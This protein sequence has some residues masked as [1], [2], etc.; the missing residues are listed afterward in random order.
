MR[1]SIHID[2]VDDDD[3]AQVTK[4]QLAGNGT[5]RF[6]I[7]LK[8]RIAKV[9]L[10][11]ITARIDVDRRH[12]FGLVDDQV[13]PGL[14]VHS[15]GECIA[16]FFIDAEML[17]QRFFTD[18][19]LKDLR[20]I[21]HKDLGEVVKLV[22]IV[23][24]IDQDALGAIA[25]QITK[26]ALFQIKVLV[27]KTRSGAHARF[28]LD[29]LP[30]TLQIDHVAFELFARA[31][32]GTGTHDVAAFL[33]LRHQG[34][35]DRLQAFPFFMTFNALRNTDVLFFGHVD[36]FITGQRNRRRQTSAFGT[37]G[38]FGHL[39]KNGVARMDCVFDGLIR[40]V[41]ATSEMDVID[42]KKS[43]AL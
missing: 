43:R 7:G 22:V 40:A 30:K 2:K 39:N 14:Q 36:Q 6:Q 25:H 28:V 19:A 27:E 9:A 42:M 1:I 24:R 18:I 31:V 3:T 13:A 12:G 34:R 8:H 10:T 4:T 16:D 17:E 35:D 23:L 26:R 15:T 11:D 33:I 38:L 37:N 32:F 41:F 20:G 5:C 21:G 29:L